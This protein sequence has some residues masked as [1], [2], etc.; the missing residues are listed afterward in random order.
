LGLGYLII[1]ADYMP[2]I[3][4]ILLII[5]S[6]GY[7]IDSLASLLSRQYGSNETFFVVL[8]AVPA[9]IA[10]YSLALWLLVRGGKQG[11]LGAKSC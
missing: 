2:R 1:K 11:A 5:S 3:I 6:V 8:V 9:L 7:L 4:G 10:E